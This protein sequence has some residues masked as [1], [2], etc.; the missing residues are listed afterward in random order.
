[1][2]CCTTRSAPCLV[3]VKTSARFIGSRCTRCT[4]SAGLSGFSTTIDRLLD[5]HCGRHGCDFTAP[6]W[7]GACRRACGSPAAWWP[8]RA[9]SAAA[10]GSR[11]IRRTSWM[12][13]MSSMRSASSS[14]NTSMPR[15]DRRGA[16]MRSSSRPGV[17]TRCQR[18]AQRRS[19]GVCPT[20]PKMVVWLKFSPLPYVG[21]ALGDLRRQFTRW[22]EHQAARTAAFAPLCG[23]VFSDNRC[24]IGTANAAVLPV[25][26]CARPSTSFPP[27]SAESPGPEWESEPCIPRP[28][29]PREVEETIEV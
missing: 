10:W 18:P 20:P 5:L 15:L 2:R 16:A 28:R 9:A 14:T 25:P 19:C 4:S 12:K 29:W 6:G 27:G 24:R 23:A 22:R 17:A 21:E 26:V 3:R 8:R 13:P 11:T 1:M 7:S